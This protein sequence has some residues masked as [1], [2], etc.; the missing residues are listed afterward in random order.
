MNAKSDPA[1]SDLTRIH[2]EVASLLQRI[3]DEH[4]VRI[5]R[6]YVRWFDL[7]DGH[8]IHAVEL[9]SSANV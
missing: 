5:D 9:D 7:V 2:L 4:G 6:V 8:H 3:A 1:R